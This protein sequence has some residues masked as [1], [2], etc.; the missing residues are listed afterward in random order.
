MTRLT[1]SAKDSIFRTR[2]RLK[3]SVSLYNATTSGLYKTNLDEFV[4]ELLR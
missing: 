2:E 1:T 3:A 4:T